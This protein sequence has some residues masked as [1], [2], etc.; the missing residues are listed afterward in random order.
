[1]C[2]SHKHIR[3]LQK[4]ASLSRLIRLE[5]VRRGVGLLACLLTL[6]WR[7][8]K[9]KSISKVTVLARQGTEK[10][11]FRVRKNDAVV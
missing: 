2:G 10:T 5:G 7:F 4:P 9:T 3:A 8:N 6:Y 1:M 11:L